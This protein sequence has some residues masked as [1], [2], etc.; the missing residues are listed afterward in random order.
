MK[1]FFIHH[2]FLLDNLLGKILGLV[3]CSFL[4][5]QTVRRGEQF[6][7]KMGKDFTVCCI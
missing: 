6:N 1:P 5:T 2:F 7:Q 3:F 4:S